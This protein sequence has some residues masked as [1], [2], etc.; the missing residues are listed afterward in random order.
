MQNAT[1]KQLKRKIER[2]SG[3]RRWK[4]GQTARNQDL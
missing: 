1:A 4:P 3:K 2:T